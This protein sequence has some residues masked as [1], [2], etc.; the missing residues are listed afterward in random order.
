VMTQSGAPGDPST[1]QIGSGEDADDQL[2][3]PDQVAPDGVPTTLNEDG[4]PQPG[5]EE[6]LPGQEEQAEGEA[7][8]QQGEQDQELGAEEEAEGQELANEGEEDQ[9]APEPQGALVCSNCGQSFAPDLAAQPGVPCPACRQG[10]LEPAGG[11]QKEQEDPSLE[12]EEEDEKMPG[13]KTAA[14]VMQAQAARIEVLAAENEVLREQLSFLARAAGA[15][16]HLEQ[17]RQQVM[18]KHADVLNP[19]SPVPD[20]PEEAAPQSTEQALAPD[21]MDDPSRPGTSPGSVEAVPAQQTT[22]AITPGVEDQT[23]PA[24]NLVDVTAPVQGTN[25]S[26]DGGVPLEQRRI[27]TDV[28]IDPDPLKAHG[29][30]IGGAGNDGTAFPW[31]LNARGDSSQK[32]ASRQGGGNGVPAAAEESAAAR[33]YGA[34][35]LAKLRIQ[36]G[37][38]QGDELAI[39]EVIEKDAALTGPMIEHE[40]KVLSQVRP[41][42]PARPMARQGTRSAPSLAPVGASY[43]PAPYAPAVADDLDGSDLFL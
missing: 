34:I 8:E 29:P 33:T 42:A 5:D 19:A 3:H 7:E 39:A 13:S 20:P 4:Q 18:R 36:A 37:L 9:L 21:A 38:A 41:A 43:T 40:I 26:Q 22:T 2:L 11:P 24:T 35:R 31:M 14:A 10:A 25:P 28:R 12:D 1:E 27:E 16:Q 23:P 17:I 32:A 15:D 30:G 6:Q